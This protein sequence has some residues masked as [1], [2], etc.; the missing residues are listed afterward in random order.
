MLVPCV[1][2]IKAHLE[3]C[4]AT[5]LCLKVAHGSRSR[6][7]GSCSTVLSLQLSAPLVVF[8]DPRA[9]LAVPRD[10][11]IFRHGLGQHKWGF[12]W[13]SI[14]E[15][16]GNLK[17]HSRASGCL[18]K[19]VLSPDDKQQTLP[20]RKMFAY[21]PRAWDEAPICYISHVM[22]RSSVVWPWRCSAVRAGVFAL[23]HPRDG[24]WGSRS[25]GLSIGRCPALQYF[26]GFFSV[27][28]G[29]L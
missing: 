9:M 3:G 25:K 28:S 6:R 13:R 11:Q 20:K 24:L 8:D 15:G 2:L 29:S 18:L 5:A 16:R 27:L 23:W 26:T 22:P 12:A 10:L 19:K 14:N 17:Y 4:G 7:C 21:A 1:W